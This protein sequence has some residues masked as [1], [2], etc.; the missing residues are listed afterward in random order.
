M[1]WLSPDVTCGGA[2]T[3]AQ[4]YVNGLGPGRTLRRKWFVSSPFLVNWFHLH[5]FRGRHTGRLRWN[6]PV[7]CRFNPS[8]S[9]SGETSWC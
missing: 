7:I 5:Y 4:T 6:A 3:D 9:N 2:I 1:T 8:D